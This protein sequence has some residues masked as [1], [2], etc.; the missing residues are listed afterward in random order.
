MYQL[1]FIASPMSILL[2]C[3]LVFQFSSVVPENFLPQCQATTYLSISV[4][5]N[6]MAC[7]VF[8]LLRLFDRTEDSTIVTELALSNPRFREG[9]RGD[10]T[11]YSLYG[12]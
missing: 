11:I 3:L 12:L 2:V 6:I 4:F 5:Y 7:R 10:E 1:T 8:R 9:T